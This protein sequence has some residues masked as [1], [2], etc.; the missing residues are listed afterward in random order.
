MIIIN[1]IFIYLD[2]PCWQAFC[3]AF[4]DEFIVTILIWKFQFH[5]TRI[6]PPTKFQ[7]APKSLTL[8][9]LLLFGIGQDCKAYNDYFGGLVYNATNSYKNQIVLKLS[10][11][12]SLLTNIYTMFALFTLNIIQS[13]MHE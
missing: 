6:V 10:K 9:F 11:H 12:C 1:K 4:S 2:G 8:T 7:F 5:T 13:L 3:A